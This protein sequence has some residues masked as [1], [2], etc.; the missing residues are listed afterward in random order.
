MSVFPAEFPV[1]LGP[2]SDTRT[3]EA[4][5]RQL[6]HLLPRGRLWDVVPGSLLDRLLFAIGDE[7]ARV[8]SRGADLLLEAD[9]RTATETIGDWERVLGVTPPPGATPEDRRLAITAAL[10]Q[11]G[12]QTPAYYTAIAEAAGYSVTIIPS[13]SDLVLRAGFRAGARCYG[14]EWAHTWEV[15]VS[16]PAGAALSHGELEALI[17][18]AAPAHSVVIF[19]YL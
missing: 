15:R 1:L 4:Y 9:P 19:T 13:F 17:R 11:Q 2:D 8:D 14:V 10:V 16:P 12:G 18:S 7:L 3:A 5:A 6:R